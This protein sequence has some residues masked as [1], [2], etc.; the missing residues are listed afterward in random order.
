ME[1]GKQIKKYRTEAMMSEVFRV[2]LD[3]IYYFTG[4]AGTTRNVMEMVW[5]GTVFMLVWNWNVFCCQD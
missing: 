2:S 4:S 3:H 5:N 1:L